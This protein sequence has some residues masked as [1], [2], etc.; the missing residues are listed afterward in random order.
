MMTL[1]LQ[2]SALTELGDRVSMMASGFQS[3]ALDFLLAIAIA[4]VAWALALIVS[5]V[6]RRV[7]GDRKSVV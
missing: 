6:V 3:G 1:I 5:G 2:Q 4:V 7:L